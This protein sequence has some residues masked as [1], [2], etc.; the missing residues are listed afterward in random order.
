VE[1]SRRDRYI[2]LNIAD[3]GKGLQRSSDTPKPSIGMVGMRARARQAGGD[4]RVDSPATGGVAL[5]AWVPLL[6]YAESHA[7]EKIPH[8]V[9]R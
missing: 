5:A 3:N 7:I 4:F 9:G 8:P 6:N 1:L 2:W